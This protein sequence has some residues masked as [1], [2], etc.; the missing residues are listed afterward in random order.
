MSDLKTKVLVAVGTVAAGCA[1]Y[2]LYRRHLSR[3]QTR[4]SDGD[5]ADDDLAMEPEAALPEYKV[6]VLG[7]DGSGK[8]SLLAALAGQPIPSSIPVTEGFH[9]INL[10]EDRAVW[11]LWEVGGSQ[12]CRTHWPRFFAKTN[13][14]V[15]VVDSADADRLEQSATTLMGILGDEE[16]SGVPLLL[17]FNKQDITGAARADEL[18]EVFKLTELLSTRTVQ[19]ASCQVPPPDDSG[20]SDTSGVVQVKQLICTMCGGTGSS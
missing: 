19:L 1:A 11:N 10:N 14:L 3:A 17:A 20:V 12:S 4:I 2:M 13:L 16:L 5:L 15:Y 18:S 7:L 9:V 8:S 6:L